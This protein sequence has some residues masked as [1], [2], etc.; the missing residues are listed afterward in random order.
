MASRCCGSRLSLPN[1]Y[2]TKTPR[3]SLS[4]AAAKKPRLFLGCS[5]PVPAIVR[6]YLASR[7]KYTAWVSKMSLEKFLKF[8]QRKI[9][10]K[11]FGAS[12]P[13][14][15]ALR[16]SAKVL[17]NVASA[18]RKLQAVLKDRFLSGTSCLLFC[19]K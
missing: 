16:T 11:F 7:I 14:D 17:E 9:S 19:G 5:S 18:R 10:K 6:D 13:P 2:D 1:Q 12:R 8:R 15:F 3:A 4:S